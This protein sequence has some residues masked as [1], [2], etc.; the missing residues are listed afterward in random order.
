MQTTGT[1]QDKSIKSWTP[2]TLGKVRSPLQR[3]L[4]AVKTMLWLALSAGLALVL[5]ECILAVSHF[6]EQEYMQID[7][8]LGVTHLN[9]KMITW[10]TEGFSHGK[11]NS[12]GFFDL[13]RPINKPTGVTRVAFFG[14]SFTEA[15]QV[16]YAQ[17]F[18]SQLE[19][20][21]NQ[22]AQQKFQVM[23][24]G[25][26]GFSTGQEYLLYAD[27]LGIFEPD[28]AIVCI[29]QWE[30]DKNTV[31]PA[32]PTFSLSNT[33]QLEIRWIDFDRWCKS[34]A[35]LPFTFFDWARRNSRVWGVLLQ[36]YSDLKGDRT[37]K[38]LCT[39]F[40]PIAQACGKIGPN[41]GAVARGNAANDEESA[42]KA[43]R[44][45]ICKAAGLVIDET[46]TS[47]SAQSTSAGDLETESGSQPTTVEERWRVTRA[48][49]QQFA[50]ACSYRHCQLILVVLPVRWQ[51]DSYQERFNWLAS[52]D[53]TRPVPLLN[54]IPAYARQQSDKEQPMFLEGHLSPKGHLLAANLIYDFLQQNNLI[55]GNQ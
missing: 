22:G 2:P 1:T 19:S 40:T 31:W 44:K 33:G 9:N 20:E 36:A 53:T 55:P 49:I 37:Y 5:L 39:F 12:A 23:N 26:S 42:I 17:R 47:N 25:V 21:L 38:S 52:I 50:A 29:N 14:D 45:I 54:M 7:P 24:F 18:T 10:R 51:K 11:I 8:Y 6:G 43:R 30:P 28:I 3:I 27:R 34:S 48:I 16:P 35:A 4:I 46:A 32:R 13:E 41:S 15:V